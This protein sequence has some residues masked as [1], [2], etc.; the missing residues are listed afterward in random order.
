MRWPLTLTVLLRL[1]WLFAA[2]AIGFLIAS[3]ISAWVAGA[4][5]SAA[6]VLPSMA[7]F[8][9]YAASLILPRIGRIGWYRLAMIPALVFFGGGGVIG[10]IVNFVE[11]GPSPDMQVF[12]A[13][14][15]LVPDE[16]LKAVKEIIEANI[17]TSEDFHHTDS[18]TRIITRIAHSETVFPQACESLFF[19]PPHS[20]NS[21]HRMPLKH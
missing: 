7:L 21:D 18:L 17:S 11:R 16:A 4:P 19:C 5:L 12:E 15:H 13:V 8:A 3:G 9:L 10:N 2:L 6:P 14:C 20:K 1:Q